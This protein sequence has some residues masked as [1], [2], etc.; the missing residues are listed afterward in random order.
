LSAFDFSAPYVAALKLKTHRNPYLSD[1]FF[2]IWHGAGGSQA[3]KLVEAETKPVY[4]PNAIFFFLPFA[5]L[6]WH[7]A[8]LAYT[9]LCTCLFLVLIVRFA[10]M[11]G[12]SWNSWRRIAFLAFALALA[13]IHTAIS[14]G[15]PSALSVSCCLG[16]LICLWEDRQI[17]AGILLALA[18]IIKPSSGPLIVVLMLIYRRW[19][20]LLTLTAVYGTLSVAALAMM[21]R[22]APLWKADYEN[23]IN[24]FFFSA[25]G[26]GNFAAHMGNR[27]DALNLQV[28]LFEL[29]QSKNFANCAATVIFGV[30]FV[31]WVVLALRQRDQRFRFD[32]M[33]IAVLL[34]LMP[35]YQRNY[36]AGVVLVAIVWAFQ[37]LERTVAKWMLA[38]CCVFILPLEAMLR[39]YY[40]WV[41]EALKGS[42]VLGAFIFPVASWSIL[43]LTIL[44]L[45][46]AKGSPRAAIAAPGS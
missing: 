22:V 15:N 4:A 38:I 29:T 9:V 43:A 34:A 26:D 39:Y 10:S 44:L 13:P 28:P 25:R 31:A 37:N 40:G 35:V 20:S 2:S 5:W 18:L 27:F 21:G 23:N 14:T 1:D 45:V 11:V 8:V 33:S 16:A 32:L 7:H 6:N 30:L 42:I 24:F 17:P 19:K 41:P 46:V 3:V 12:D 36:N